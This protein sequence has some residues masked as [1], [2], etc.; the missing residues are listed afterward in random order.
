[1]KWSIDSADAYSV[2]TVR[3]AVIGELRELTGGKGDL[4]GVELVLGEMLGA[5][6]ER[7]HIALVVTVERGTAGPS[8]HIYTQGRPGATTAVQGE[9]RRAILQHV[10]V[11][12]SVED[13]PQGTH[14]VM[15]LEEAATRLDA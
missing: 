15:R 10:R 6:T 1:M 9:L 13:S 5:E 4:S 2:A 7:G 12:M 14:I 3:R 11:P 8:V